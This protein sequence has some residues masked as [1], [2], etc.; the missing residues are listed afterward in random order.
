MYTERQ[1]DAQPSRGRGKSNVL[2]VTFRNNVPCLNVL[3]TRRT[4]IKVSTL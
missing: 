2:T 4:K 3:E 1:R